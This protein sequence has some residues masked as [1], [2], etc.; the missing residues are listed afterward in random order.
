MSLCAVVGLWGAVSMLALPGPLSPQHSAS[1]QVRT[2]QSLLCSRR[3]Q[4]SHTTSTSLHRPASG[5]APPF[6]SVCLYTSQGLSSLS[7]PPSTPSPFFPEQEHSQRSRP[8]SHVH[9]L[10]VLPEDDPQLVFYFPL[11]QSEATLLVHLHGP[12]LSVRT[13]VSQKERPL[14]WLSNH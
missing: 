12:P 14:T 13:G 8:P 9:L 11:K 7:P 4:L 3:L 2:H 5:S 10:W 1:S 6:L